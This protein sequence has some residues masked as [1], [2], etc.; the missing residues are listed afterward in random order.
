M[1]NNNCTFTMMTLLFIGVIQ[2]YILHVRKTDME[3]YAFSKLSGQ[4]QG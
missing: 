4:Y 2:D 1:K 3:E